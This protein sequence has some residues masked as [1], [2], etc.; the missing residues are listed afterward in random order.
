MR[1]KSMISGGLSL[2][3]FCKSSPQLFGSVFCSPKCQQ[4]AIGQ[5]FCQSC[6]TNKIWKDPST[7]QKSSFCSKKCTQG[8]NLLGGVQQ[9]PKTGKPLQCQQCITMTTWP[10]I[11]CSRSCGQ[12]FKGDIPLFDLKIVDPTK[13]SSVENQF[14]KQW[15]GTAPKVLN[16]F[17]IYASKRN[18]KYETYKAG[19][20]SKNSNTSNEQRRWHGTRSQCDIIAAAGKLCT[21][22]SCAVCNICKTGFQLQF[23]SAGNFGKG[24]YFAKNPQKS[25]AYNTGSEK[26]TGKRVIFLCK[27]TLGK[28]YDCGTTTNTTLTAPPSGY[29]SVHGMTNYDELIVYSDEACIP[30]YILFYQYV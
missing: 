29:D 25:H 14:Q 24:L 30:S 3:V 22:A 27:V 15:G 23:A 26:Q 28:E 10:D 13:Y 21:S 2:C 20:T 19:V 8:S 11:F 5:D 1:N 6:G 18:T 4:T 17:S 9:K 12:A 7:G 16:I